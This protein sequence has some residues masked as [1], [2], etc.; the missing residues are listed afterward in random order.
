MARHYYNG[1]VRDYNISIQ[2]FPA[3]LISRNLGYREAAMFD[4][5]E[6]SPE[7]AEV[8]FA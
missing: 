6:I 7:P 4:T 5:D 8:S 1:S 2:S 3:A